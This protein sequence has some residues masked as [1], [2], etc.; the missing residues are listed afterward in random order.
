MCRKTLGLGRSLVFMTML[1]FILGIVVLFSSVF[2][3]QSS[4]GITS[5]EYSDPSNQNVSLIKSH[6]DFLTANGWSTKLESKSDN[7]W[8]FPQ[9]RYFWQFF[10]NGTFNDFIRQMSEYSIVEFIE[11]F[12]HL[13]QQEYYLL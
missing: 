5:S 8:P 12:Q 3:I 7:S 10:K 11:S 2:I 13:I 4:F 1:A 9:D 6:E